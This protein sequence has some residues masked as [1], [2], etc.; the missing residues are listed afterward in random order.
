MIETSHQQPASAEMVPEEPASTASA[1]SNER[2]R[3][4]SHAGFRTTFLQKRLTI[5]VVVPIESYPRNPVPELHNH[6]ERAMLVEKLGFASLWLRDVPFLVPS[7]GDAGQLFDPFVYLGVLSATTRRIA[8]GV[9][10]VILPIRHPVHVAKSAFSVDALSGGRLL[11]GIASGDR[12]S[13]YPAMGL[14]FQ[15]RG[16]RFRESV[17]YLRQAEHAWPRLDNSYG[18]LRGDMDLLP[19]PEFGGIPLLVTGHS[20]QSREWIAEHAD[21]WMVYPQAA[22]TQAA[23]VEQMRAL[24]SDVDRPEVPIAQPLHIDLVEDDDYPP[25]MI[26]LGIRTGSRGLENY[27][28]ALE[29]AGV[30]HVMLNL[31]FQHG[32]VEEVLR[33][34]AGD[35][36]KE[37]IPEGDKR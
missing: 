14:D 2:H 6:L 37:W 20:Q 10:S 30:R 17:A 3:F 11:L 35:V 31:R 29:T 25:K 28:R 12:P 27:V 16:E 23:I 21:G 32:D 15:T 13:E 33:R 36:L 4:S 7:F 26:H 34:L 24:S 8:L 22:S 1:I 5:G 18:R 9:A 19:K